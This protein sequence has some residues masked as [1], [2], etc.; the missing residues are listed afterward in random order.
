MAEPVFGVNFLLIP[1]VFALSA[2]SGTVTFEV[3]RAA[4]RT[5]LGHGWVGFS[6]ASYFAAF[7]H[8]GLSGGN[9][10]RSLFFRASA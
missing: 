9:T 8:T 4:L 6:V 7:V 3:L 10:T 5:P 1:F 2:A